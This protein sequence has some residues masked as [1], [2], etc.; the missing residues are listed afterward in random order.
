MNRENDNDYM[1]LTE[2][3]LS[4]IFMI[5]LIGGCWMFLLITY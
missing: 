3:I 2:I 4:T 5:C 1:T